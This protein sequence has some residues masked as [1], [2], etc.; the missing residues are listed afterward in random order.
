MSQS[1]LPIVVTPSLDAKPWGGRRL[2]DWGIALPQGETIGEAHLAA[3]EATVATGAL[4]GVP[5]DQLAR[6]N[7]GAWIGARG[8]AATGG[9]SIFPLLVKLITAE[10]DL[11]IQVHPDDRAAAA[12]GLGTGKT[13]AYHILSAAPGSGIY[14][15][16]APD[17]TMA[18]LAAAC[19]LADGSA[20]TF[21]RRV[22]AAP[23]MTILIPAGTVH[24]L[25]A[26]ITV[27]E[28]Q[29]P[30]NTTF[31]LDDWGRVD[32]AGATR[33]LHHDQG[34]AV[35]DSLSRPA[36]IP[37]IVFA[38][39]ASRRELLVATRHFALERIAI[40]D[41]G[42]VRLDGVES[43]QVL[44]TIGGKATLDA[45][46]WIASL[47]LGATVIVPVG[48]S[49]ELTGSDDAVMLRGWVP[50]LARDV[51]APARAAGATG[52]AIRRLGGDTA[53]ESC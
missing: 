26:G 46:G 30:S 42:V 50:D 5:L 25:G 38:D 40:T 47:S 11:S 23:G 21:L 1:L 18:E 48:L 7:P 17:A 15:G 33:Q 45:L 20:A 14:L 4:A 12:A 10:T 41:P 3:P 32:A 27:Y 2:T 8:L 39:G 9:R 35:V 34:F 13:E 6:E 36:P 53:G 28:I 52:D 16:L 22:P 49:A 43:P 51:I 37:P 44:T 31:R 29:Q 19:R 24:A